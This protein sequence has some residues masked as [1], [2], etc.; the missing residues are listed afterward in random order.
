MFATVLL[1]ACASVSV[2]SHSPDATGALATIL[3]RGTIVVG[4]AGNMPPLNMIDKQGQLFGFEVDMAE[5]IA[6]GLGVTLKWTP[7][8]FAQLLPALEQGDVDMILSGMTITMQ[9]N[10]SVAFVGPY[11]VSGKA[12]LTKIETIAA[13]KDTD[14]LNSPQITLTA[15]QNST[16][17]AFVSEV[18]PNARLIETENYAQSIQLVLND[19]VQAMVADY[20]ICAVTV[21]RNPGKGLLSVFTPFTYEPLG[22]GVRASDPHLINWLENFLKIYEGTGRLDTLE[23]KWFHDGAWLTQLP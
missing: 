14:R 21:F 16:S 5:D 6:N 1:S 9:R 15:L 4:T 17:A 22:I 11:I 19:K 3:K 18:I 8:P 2:T 12:F 7:L 20:P 10:R 23:A 13:T